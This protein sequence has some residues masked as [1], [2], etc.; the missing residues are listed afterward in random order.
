MFT[1]RRL[2]LFDGITCPDITSCSRNPCLFSHKRE[3]S[4][5]GPI[6]DP[7]TLSTA[8]TSGSSGSPAI[9]PILKP[10]LKLSHSSSSSEPSS[11]IPAK[12]PMLASPLTASP[13]LS[14]ANE[15]PRKLLRVGRL[16]AVAVNFASSSKSVCQLGVSCVISYTHPFHR[17]KNQVFPFFLFLRAPARSPSL[18]VNSA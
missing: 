1:S 13:I 17:L 15:P 11:S 6:K 18:L 16:K 8:S 14:P 5:D 2:G 10:I 7:P 4:G 3:L 12:R 9:K